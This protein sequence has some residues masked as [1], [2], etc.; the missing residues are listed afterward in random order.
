MT[1]LSS[2]F[3]GASGRR[4][5]SRPMRR[6]ALIATAGLL[7]AG[8]MWGLAGALAADPSASLSSGKVSTLRI[9]WTI[10]PDNLNQFIGYATSAYEV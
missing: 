1:Q 8:L 10:E 7:V 3:R 4:L 6:L 9:G 5:R 2:A